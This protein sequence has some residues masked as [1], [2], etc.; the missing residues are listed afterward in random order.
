MDDIHKSKMFGEEQK[1]AYE[2]VYCP[3]VLQKKKRYA[4]LKY[5]KATDKP[6]HIEKGTVVV[7]RDTVRFI[8]S[9]ARGMMDIILKS[10]DDG[11]RATQVELFLRE[12]IH[13]VLTLK[14]GMEDFI[15]SNKLTK[16][17]NEYKN[18]GIN[19]AHVRVYYMWKERE[20]QTCPVVGSRVP[21]VLIRTLGKVV[22]EKARPPFMVKMTGL[23]VDYYVREKLRKALTPVLEIL[24]GERK[25]ATIFNISQRTVTDYYLKIYENK[26]IQYTQTKV[27]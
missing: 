1:I 27:M 14:L 15:I 21:Y 2:C 9:I 18:K 22:G 25:M 19:I 16:S 26:E 6:K 5:E 4:A 8:S 13:A 20:P 24:F 11:D 3:F 17:P 12:R 23:D 10:V 7:R